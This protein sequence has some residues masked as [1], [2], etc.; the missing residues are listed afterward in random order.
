MFLVCCQGASEESRLMAAPV[1]TLD[2]KVVLR[3]SLLQALG[4]DR[5]TKISYSKPE[6]GDITITWTIKNN[7]LHPSTKAAAQI[8]ATTILK[9]LKDSKTRFIYVVLIGTISMPDQKGQE[10]NI[11]VINLG[12]NKSKLDRVDWEDFQF[13]D[14]YDLAD[15]ADI[16]DGWK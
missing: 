2:E 6:A 15:V 10:T 1:A 8:D 13:S 9:V 4:T 12:F 11:Q 16:A 5:L 14:I 3:E 7:D